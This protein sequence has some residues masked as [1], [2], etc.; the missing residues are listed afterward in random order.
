MPKSSQCE[1]PA[2]YAIGPQEIPLCLGCGAIHQNMIDRQLAQLN[3]QAERA[4]D[5]MKTM[6]GVR[7]P[8]RR[9]TP[10][11]III[12]GATF[13]N[14]NIHNSDVGRRQHRRAPSADRVL[15]PGS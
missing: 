10:P 7:L 14:I 4:L 2:I 5:D 6:T 15:R 13:H 9:H 8:G 11:P 3:R 12:P 1:R